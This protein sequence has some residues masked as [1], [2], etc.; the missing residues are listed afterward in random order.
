MYVL[1]KQQIQSSLLHDEEFV[2]FLYF[3]AIKKNHVTLHQ[4]NLL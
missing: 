4:I 1:S 2:F 3:N